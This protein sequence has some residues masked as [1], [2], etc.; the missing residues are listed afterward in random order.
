MIETAFLISD[1]IE[2]FNSSTFHLYQD[3]DEICLQHQRKVTIFIF[4][5]EKSLCKLPFGKLSFFVFLVFVPF[6][7]FRGIMKCI[8]TDFS[9]PI[10]NGTM[11]CLKFQPKSLILIEISN[12]ASLSF[13]LM[14]YQGY[15][16]KS[17]K[18]NLRIIDN[19]YCC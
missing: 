5:R 17:V 19:Y 10:L 6:L 3:W 4:V 8:L 14:W 11:T 9:D 16:S 13:P 1:K 2:Y 12:L 18:T 15:K 7:F